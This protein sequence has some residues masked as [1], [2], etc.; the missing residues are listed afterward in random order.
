MAL[1]TA[2]GNARANGLDGP[3]D[4]SRKFEWLEV[5]RRPLDWNGPA[6]RLF[7]R[8]RHQDLQRPIIEQFQRVARQQR[9]R[10]AIRD[11]DTA[12]SFGELWGGVSGLAE[13]LAAETEPGDL[14]GILLPACPMFPLAMLACLASG[15]PFV[16]LDTRYPPDWLDQVLRDARP[17][18]IIAPQDGLNDIETRM[19]TVR[20]IRL[21]G[22]LKPARAWQPATMGV[23]EPAC[24]LFTSGSTG[25]PKGIV[26]SQRGLLQRVAQSINAA[27]I[28]AADRLLTL[29]SPC[30]IVGVRDVMTALLAGAS[31]HLLDPQGVGAREIVN[32][33]RGESITILFAFPALLRSILAAREGRA[34]GSLRLVRVG[35][36]T[37]VWSDVEKLRDWLPP[38]A[39]IQLVYAATEAPMM[40]WLVDD[41][42]RRDDARIP[43]GYPLPGN[44]L[45]L[46]DEEGRAT[47]PGEVGELVVGSPYV[48]LGRWLDGRLAEESVESVGC[49]SRVF[50]TGDLVR[51]RND[52]LLERVGRKDRQ[53]K[54]RGSRVDLDGIEA[55]LRGHSF[56][57]DV[58]V[59]ARPTS[60]DGTITLVAYVSARVGAPG[61]LFDELK[62][63]MHSAA[64]PMR[65]GRFYLEPA[66]PRLSSSKLDVRALA[67]LDE[68]RAQGE[69]GESIDRATLAPMAGDHVSETVARVWQQ[70]LHV[71]VRAAD[72][73]FFDSGGDSLNAIAFVLELERALG[74]EISLTLINEAPRFDQLC[75]ALRERRAPGSSLLV[76]LKAG[77]AVPPVFFIHGI[78][79]NVV[80]ILPTAR[81]VTYPGAAI[82][83]RARGAVRGEV[84]H[85]SIEAMAA[86]YLREIK[87]YQPNGPYHL[88]GYSSGGLIAFEMARRLSESGD[89]V[90]LVGLFDTT[91]SPVRWP[92]RAW[93]SIIARRVVL[94]AAALRTVPIRA[95]RTR[96]RTSAEHLRAWRASLGASPSL[97]LKVA[98]STLVASAR[99]HP[100]FYRGTLTLFSPAEREPGLPSLESVW[101]RHARTVTVVH[102]PGAHS[103]MLSQHHAE[104]TAA[105]VTRCLPSPRS[106]HDWSSTW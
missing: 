56:V 16:A 83:I 24:V 46:V 69:R 102:T 85:A 96:L 50:R 79:G 33:I 15:R 80:E 77:D 8:F 66:I 42:C 76:T 2:R 18:V 92:L 26:N 54:V 57:R 71:P 4:L 88:C 40:Q 25:R 7:T 11:A 35:G 64:P 72:D 9:G 86:E 30:T 59:V 29:A 14:I 37:T 67:A 3:F 100:G 60:A 70:V 48:S 63:L 47:L 5:D 95:W 90:G 103:T 62:A 12:L 53:V 55:I 73:D 41:G 106:R 20:V 74:L 38:D 99:F 101:A 104:A 43:I 65:P 61:G 52:G 13:T 91:M 81:R 78:G 21:M 39:A 23:D 34:D 84:S 27:H 45:A 87:E 75:Q 44:R 68:A 32:V 10:I 6:N 19:P 22:L 82:G 58:A 1:H 94:V 49:G 28:N 51:Q 31:I 93:R 17:T 97:A 89:E 98:A 105:C 36:D